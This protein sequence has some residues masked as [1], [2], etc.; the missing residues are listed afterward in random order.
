MPA[1]SVFIPAYNEQKRLKRNIDK[2]YSIIHR[3]CQNFEIFIIDDSSNDGTA[4]LSREIAARLPEVKFVGYKN[5]P[6]RREN[7]A[8]SFF[9]SEGKVILYMDADLAT[10]LDSFAELLKGINAGYDIVTGSR[11]HKDSVV[12]RTWRRKTYSIAYNNLLQFL[13]T[14]KINDHQC[15]FKAFKRQTILPI[16]KKMGYDK[17]FIRKWFWD[18]ELLIRAQKSK[19][20]ILEIP[21]IWKESPQSVFNFYTEFKMIFYILGLM[22]RLPK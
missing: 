4:E 2:I 19:M 14:S 7:L 17:K 18:A 8:K 1:I 13:F 6:S 10:S 22:F 12:D 16:I 20:K 9:L 11:Y 21:V 3:N 15:G 5:G